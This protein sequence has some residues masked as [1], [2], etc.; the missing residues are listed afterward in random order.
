[1]PTGAAPG[2]LPR[3]YLLIGQRDPW[4]ATYALAERTLAQRGARVRA[5]RLPRLGHA[6]PGGK[7]GRE[8]LQEALGWV[9]E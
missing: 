1:M 7:R 6:M 9:L 3:W 4:V 2:T 5:K 8:H